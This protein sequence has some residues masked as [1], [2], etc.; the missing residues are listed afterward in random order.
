MP[1]QLMEEHGGR[2]LIINVNGRLVKADYERVSPEFERLVKE[3]GKLR[4]LFDMTDFH[5]W[6]VGAAWQDVKL[7]FAHFDHIDRLALVGEKKW[8][9]GMA[10]FCRPFTRATV[11]YFD[12][13]DLEKAR[14][15]IDEGVAYA[16]SDAFEHASRDS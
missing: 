10:A 15:W 11:R 1:I 5:G 6:D 7:G 12:H 4:V 9:R 8:Q 3:H 13:A 14:K 2:V 16:P